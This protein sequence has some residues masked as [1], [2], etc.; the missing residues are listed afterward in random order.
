MQSLFKDVEESQ[1]NLIYNRNEALSFDNAALL[2]YLT[3]LDDSSCSPAGKYEDAIH[4]MWVGRCACKIFFR[5]G[6]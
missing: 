6:K 3:I 2:L 1:S 5:N 4:I